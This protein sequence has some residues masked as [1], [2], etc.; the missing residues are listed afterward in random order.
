MDD[1]IRHRLDFKGPFGFLKQQIY[2]IYAYAYSFYHV[3]RRVVS[4]IVCKIYWSNYCS[5]CSYVSCLATV[6]GS[7]K[8]LSVLLRDVWWRWC[9]RRYNQII[10]FVT[11]ST[12]NKE[13]FLASSF[14]L[15]F[16]VPFWLDATQHNRMLIRRKMLHHKVN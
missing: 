8:N 7:Q 6:I 4:K 13:T 16:P 14:R 12:M 1:L 11:V 3:Y 10:K 2:G 15:G 9:F 5:T